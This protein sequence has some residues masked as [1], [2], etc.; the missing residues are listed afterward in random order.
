VHISPREQEK[1]LL[2]WAAEVATRRRTRGLRLNHQVI[3]CT[4]CRTGFE[5][6]DMAGCPFHSEPDNMQAICSLCCSLEK[7]CHDMCKKPGGQSEGVVDLT[8][9]PSAPGHGRSTRH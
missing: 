2:L 6:P 4:V 3:E 1:L 9:S 5:R 8:V 7:G